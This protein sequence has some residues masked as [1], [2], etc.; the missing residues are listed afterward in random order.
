MNPL[1][2]GIGIDIVDIRKLQ[3]AH[4]KWGD[5]FL[6]KIFSPQEIDYC[7]SKKNSYQHLAGRFACKEAVIK[8]LGQN[9]GFKNITIYNTKTGRP[10]VEIDSNPFDEKI[11]VFVSLS[12][13][14]SYATAVA[15]VVKKT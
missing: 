14:E 13:L 2:K 11:E 9:I 6:K 8:A 12:H 15:V 4:Q 5:F 7:F 10:C 1:I 3:K